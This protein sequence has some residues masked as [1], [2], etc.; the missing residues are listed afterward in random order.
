MSAETIG[1]FASTAITNFVQRPIAARIR[2]ILRIAA[3]L[4]RAVGGPRSCRRI[5][6]IHIAGFLLNDSPQAFVEIGHVFDDEYALPVAGD[7]FQLWQVMVFG[8][9]DGK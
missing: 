1:A 6:G 2:V 9:S 5:A 8:D 4:R 7:F 3:D